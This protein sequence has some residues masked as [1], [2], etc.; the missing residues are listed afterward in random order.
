MLFRPLEYAGVKVEVYLH[1]Y[2][3]H[4]CMASVSRLIHTLAPVAYEV[5]PIGV[6]QY[7]HRTFTIMRALYL[8]LRNWEVG[9][10]LD[11]TVGGRLGRSGSAPEI[12][13]RRLGTRLSQGS[14]PSARESL[15]QGL[16][17]K[18]SEDLVVLCRFEAEYLLPIIYWNV[19][20]TA[21][22][23]AFRDGLDSDSKASDLLF[24]APHRL[25]RPLLAALG[26]STDVGHRVWWPFVGFT[27]EQPHFIDPLLRTGSGSVGVTQFRTFIGLRRDCYDYNRMCGA[28]ASSGIRAV[29]STASS[30]QP[31]SPSASDAAVW[32]DGLNEDIQ[33]VLRPWRPPPPP[34]SRNPTSSTSSAL[35]FVAC[36]VLGSPLLC[37]GFGTAVRA[38]RGGRNV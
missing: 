11:A 28:S 23:M 13:T 26:E 15:E 36:I 9:T 31:A 33:G 24:V 17:A 30:L 35:Q 27:G 1:A 5:E 32:A 38:M 21:L 12:G 18:R 22:N 8:V 6:M 7:A 20:P 16:G 10:R 29:N 14:V 37:V 3:A 25:I 34:F 2:S 4:G 19:R